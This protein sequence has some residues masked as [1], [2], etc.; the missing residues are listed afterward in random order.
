M[1]WGDMTVLHDRDCRYVSFHAGV[2]RTRW[3]TGDE[4]KK[5]WSLWK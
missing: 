1:L 5:P 3:A 2:E 4:F